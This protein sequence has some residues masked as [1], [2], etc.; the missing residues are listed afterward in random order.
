MGSRSGMCVEDYLRILQNNER[1]IK[2]SVNLSY[3]L[4]KLWAKGLLTEDQY[5]LLQEMPYE[6]QKNSQLVQFL[7]TKG[8]GDAMHLFIQAL[9]EESEHLGHKT[10]AV[11]LL[12]EISA[13]KS[14]R[15]L[16]PPVAKKPA[17]PTPLRKSK[18]SN[19]ITAPFS[20]PQP[21]RKQPLFPL[22]KKKSQSVGTGLDEE[23]SSWV[24]HALAYVFFS[25]ANYYKLCS[26]LDYIDI[27]C[28][29]G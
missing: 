7:Q 29:I 13:I 6:T 4:P 17:P 3:L 10:L 5:R 20:T 27:V 15:P 18:V 8:G 12:Q 16:P 25:V 9:Q 22:H 1:T 28:V 11:T 26:Y 14:S 21:V 24:C 19:T 23:P 2:N